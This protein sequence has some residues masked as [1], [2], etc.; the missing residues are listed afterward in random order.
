MVKKGSSI[1]RQHFVLLVEDMP[2]FNTAEITTIVENGDRDASL[3]IILAPGSHKIPIGTSVHCIF[4]VKK[5]KNSC[6]LAPKSLTR[7]TWLFE[8][9]MVTGM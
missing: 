6:M 3:D 9:T 5:F 7:H 4:H 2:I 8:T 1:L